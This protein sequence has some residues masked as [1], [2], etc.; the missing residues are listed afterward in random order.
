[1]RHSSIHFFAKAIDKEAAAPTKRHSLSRDPGPRA[2]DGHQGEA[3]AANDTCAAI[4]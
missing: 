1:M 3:L 4:L 2:L